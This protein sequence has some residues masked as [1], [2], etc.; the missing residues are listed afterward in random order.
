MKVGATPENLLESI[1]LK[2]GYVPRPILDTQAS[3][4]FVRAIQVAVQ[5][6]V[7]D[8]LSSSPL[9]IDEIAAHCNLHPEPLRKL[10]NA[11]AYSGYL[12]KD[13]ECYRLGIVA[14]RWLLNTNHSLRNYVVGRSLAWDWLNQ[15]EDFVRT[16][17]AVQIHQEMSDQQ[18]EQYQMGMR[19]LA[20]IS[21]ARV[22]RCTP[23]PPGAR[24]MLD[25]GGAHGFYSVMLCRRYPSLQATILELPEA[26]EYASPILAEEGMGDRVVYKAGNAL[27][28][29]FGVET[30]DLILISNVIH[31]FD[32][33]TNRELFHR[34]KRALRP[35]GYLVV[36]GSI[37]PLNANDQ[38]GR[39]WDLFFAMTSDAGSWTYE[40]I[41]KWQR[42]AGLTPRKP[43]YLGMPP[44]SG[45]Q[46]AVKLAPYKRPSLTWLFKQIHLF[47]SV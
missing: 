13:K 41:A 1:A 20:S 29:D 17:K 6:G 11:L 38:P 46:V 39:L 7:F 27:T 31:H 43:I 23:V 26:I 36:Q 3:M 14:R 2:V 30:Y 5:L 33:D 16:G 24:K 12:K 19:S 9:T 22:A 34:L 10:L 4:I 35:G 40:D 8:A 25:I 47:R 32:A 42:E 28:E 37:L 15:L 45:Q 21:G 18:W 44:G